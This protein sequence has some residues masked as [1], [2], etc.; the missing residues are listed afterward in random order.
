[1]ILAAAYVVLLAGTDIIGSVISSIRNAVVFDA[2]F[3]FPFL[4]ILVSIFSMSP[5]IIF[6]LYLY[7]FYKKKRN[8]VLLPIAYIAA[9]I[10]NIFD[11]I[12]NLVGI[13]SLFVNG[14]VFTVFMGQLFSLGI[15]FICFAAF[16]FLAVDCFIKFKLIGISRIV[17][18]VLA[19]IAAIQL[20]FGF[21]G[22]V[23][24]FF[25]GLGGA[26][27]LNVLFGLVILCFDLVG[28]VAAVA[29]PASQFLFWTRCVSK[30][31]KR[32]EYSDMNV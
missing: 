4:P 14:F 31:K 18:T 15:H 17:V 32:P 27:F 29:W 23:S 2:G 7:M 8:H 30:P 12:T 21:F 5:A 1:M 20:V 28:A 24:G 9:A 26:G 10:I 13:V 19:L 11:M 3:S 6:V 25:L 16:V 22:I